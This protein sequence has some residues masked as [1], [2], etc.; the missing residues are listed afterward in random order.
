MRDSKTHRDPLEAL[1]NSD[2][3]Q[4][5]TD[6]LQPTG[7]GLQPIHC[8]GLQPNS[9]GLQPT[10]DGQDGDDQDCSWMKLGSTS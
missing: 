9:D 4:P 2:G 6:G 3:P 5:N 1:Y 7:D 10:S 8:N